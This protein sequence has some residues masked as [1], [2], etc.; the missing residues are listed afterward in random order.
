MQLKHLLRSDSTEEKAAPS[1]VLICKNPI[2]E[3]F[4]DA[5]LRAAPQC[6]SASGRLAKDARGV[7]TDARRVIRNGLSPPPPPPTSPPDSHQEERC[8]RNQQR[9]ASLKDLHMLPHKQSRFREP[10]DFLRT[11]KA[12]PYEDSE[13]VTRWRP[14]RAVP[15]VRRGGGGGLAGEDTRMI[16]GNMDQRKRVIGY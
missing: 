7:Q 3:L 14:Q 12:P 11:S 10:A 8:R 4:T 6:P 16:E 13:A 1:C 2:I 9:D 15:G 5:P